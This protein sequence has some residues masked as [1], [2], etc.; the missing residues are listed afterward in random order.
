[1]AALIYLGELLL[2]ETAH[3]EDTEHLLALVEEGEVVGEQL[4]FEGVGETLDHLEVE[5]VEELR[6]EAVLR[7]VDVDFVDGFRLFGLLGFFVPS[8]L[9]FVL[10]FD[11]FFL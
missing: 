5:E 10:L 2:D 11:V 7:L 4:D 9:G 3:L 1:M 8:L 6:E